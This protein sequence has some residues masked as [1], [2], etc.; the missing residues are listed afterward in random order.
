VIALPLALRGY[1]PA[2]ESLV[3]RGGYGALFFVGFLGSVTL[4]LPVPCLPLVF[5][6]GGVL[7]PYLVSLSAAAGMTFGMG[8][9]YFIG[10]IGAGVVNTV[11]AGNSTGRFA[12]WVQRSRRWF[13][14]SG[15]QSSFVLAAVP[16][17]VYDFAGIIAGSV[18]VPL[19]RFLI[20]TMLGKAVQTMGVAVAGAFA[21]GTL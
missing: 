21:T 3:Q 16:N 2:G 19:H 13:S 17:P 20:G 8:L 14:R 18:R 15:V 10:T 4:V 11:S 1:I 5:A 6:G 7:D 9:T 12:Q